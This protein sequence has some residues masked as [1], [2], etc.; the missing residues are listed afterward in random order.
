MEL[1]LYLT[2][3][4]EESA[5]DRD[6]ELLSSVVTMSSMTPVLNLSLS[7]YLLKQ[8]SIYYSV[9]LFAFSGCHETL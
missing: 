7:K 9:N 6:W 5:A 3:Y 1:W 4:V 2:Q 8:N